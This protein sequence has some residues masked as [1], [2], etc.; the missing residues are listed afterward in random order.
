MWG[1]SDLMQASVDH[2]INE[3]WKL[4]AAYNYNTESFSANQLRITAVNPVT[5]IVTRSNDGTRGSLSNVS[6]GTSDLQGGF[7][8]GGMRNQV[9]FGGDPRHRPIYRKAPSRR[10]T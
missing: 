10:P 6:Y 8:L 2:R 5:G 9:L 1:T 4:Y 7:W 3:D